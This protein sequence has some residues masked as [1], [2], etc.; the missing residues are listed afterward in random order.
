MKRR[1]IGLIILL[2][3]GMSIIG[4]SKQQRP[5]QSEDE[6]I[7]LR[8]VLWDYDVVIYDRELIENFEKDHPDIKIDVI[9]YPPT[10]YNSSLTALLDSGE[11]VDVIYVNQLDQLSQITDRNLAMPLDSYIRRD[12]VPT[13]HYPGLDVLRGKDGELLALP[14]RRD[15]FLL[16]Y[17]KDLLD[18]AGV[19]YPADTMSWI[20]F[21]QYTGEVSENL[22]SGQFAAC[23][24]LNETQILQYMR[25]RSWSG[26]KENIQLLQ[27]GMELLR[28]MQRKKYILPFSVCES[29]SASQR[30]FETGNYGLFVHG[31][32]YLNYL[33]NDRNR[34]H[35]AWGVAEKPNWR[36]DQP[37][38]AM[39][40]TPIDVVDILVVAYIIYRVMKLLKDTSAARL[41]KGSLILV[42]IMLFA[43]FLRLTMI[44]WLLRNALSVGVFAVVV[45][46]QPELRRLL[47]Q[48][49]K[50]NLSRML[51]PD[52]DPNVVESMIV[53][54]V[55]A[56]ADMSRTKTGAL[57]VFERKER[58][59]EIIA[60]GTRVDAAPSAELIKNIFFKNSPLH[61]GAM[62]VRAGRVCAA[63]CVLPLS[64]NQGLSRDLG[65]RHRAAVGMSE[66]ADSVLVVVSEETGAISVAIGGM[67]KRHL[68]PEILQK[69][70]ESELLGDELRNRNEKSR[71][72]AI[73]D[74]WKGGAGK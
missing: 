26:S 45:I 50:G 47:E 43:S 71:I 48:I 18:M 40:L 15:K 8:V 20:D 37:Y 31:T 27:D 66:T 72:A 6:S 49:G 74:K 10:Y 23:F 52:T 19:E 16:Y 32:W 2:A 61:D 36:T 17:N 68:S 63:G 7:T 60:T 55:S 5:V 58:L 57:I 14:Y 33:Q 67:L 51:I 62:I 73:R 22:W 4:V 25:D 12:G 21:M 38:N 53:A 34:F 42:L 35:F 65:T 41:A 13:E 9:S 24:L 3:V 56:C 64:G 69:M 29:Y 59:G 30:M 44:S 28:T 1:W 54:T 70:L 11:T 46:F 39:M